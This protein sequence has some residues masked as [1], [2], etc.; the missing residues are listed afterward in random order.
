MS[1]ALLRGM[2]REDA[3]K[4]SFLMSIP[5][6]VGAMAFRVLGIMRG[7]VSMADINVVNMV[8]GFLA[9]AI[10]GYLSIN[11]TLGL[12]KSAKLKY[13]AMFYVFGLAV[14]IFLF[15]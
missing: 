12:V 10:T 7:N 11:F 5:T 1:A 8:A 6:A 4:F 14:I 15:F 2:T 9:A 13:F 3:A